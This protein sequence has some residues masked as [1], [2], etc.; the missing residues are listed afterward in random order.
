M[1]GALQSLRSASLVSGVVAATLFAA[2][3]TSE[4]A[5]L[6]F[7]ALL[8]AAQENN[9]SD[10]SN[11]AGSVAVV[12]DPTAQTL[13]IIASFFNLT[14]NATM[15]HIH[16]CAPL[17]TN[18]GVATMVP[19]FTGFPLGGT[20]GTY[21][22]PLFHL[23]DSSFYN[24]AFITLQGSLAAAEAAFINGLENQLTYFNIHTTM[25]GT[26]EIRGQLNPLPTVPL[27]AA[28]PLFATGLAGLGLLGWHR[29]KKAAA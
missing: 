26:G 8:S 10:M 28:L 21:L 5:T 9:P 3:I 16:C 23:N 27:P 15:A 19:A 6:T 29:K 25:F 22:S 11:G 7:G 24:P 12:L 20:N 18:V 2:P 4:A 17:G 14:S 1:S 13:Q